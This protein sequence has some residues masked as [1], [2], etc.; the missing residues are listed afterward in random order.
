MTSSSRHVNHRMALSGTMENRPRRMAADAASNSCRRAVRTS[1][2]YSSRLSNVTAL[3]APPGSN[4]IVLHIGIYNTARQLNPDFEP[5]QFE[6]GFKMAGNPQ[7][8][9][10]VVAINA[11]NPVMTRMEELI[12]KSGN[13]DIPALNSLLNAAKFQ[14]GNQTVTNFRQLQTL[15]GDEIGNA[16]GVGTGS[17]LKTKLGIDLVNPN[18]SPGNF[19]AN[20]EQARAALQQRRN[21]LYKIQGPYAPKDSQAPPPATAPATTPA[22]QGAVSGRVGPYTY[23]VK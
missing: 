18:L 12:D 10:R 8:A 20:M 9:Q 4:S 14:L 17:D 13:T 7:I 1:S 21:E 2:T 5:A 15:L 22:P 16:L 19:R 3:L 11:I 6:L 23:V